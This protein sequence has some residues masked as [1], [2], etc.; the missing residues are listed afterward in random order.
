MEVGPISI[1]TPQETETM[2]IDLNENRYIFKIIKEEDYITLN[3]LEKDIFPNT[4][5]IKKLSFKEIKE[6][7]KLFYMLNSI[8][9]FLDYIKS[10]NENKKLTIKK[11]NNKI[12]INISVEYLFKQQIIEIPY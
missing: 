8:N 5:Y 4:T 9:E 11:D 6:L 2:T 12:I 10:A 7:H 1:V 3:I